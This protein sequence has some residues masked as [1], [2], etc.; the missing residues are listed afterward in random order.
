M[1]WSKMV[2][3]GTE[4]E[5]DLTPRCGRCEEVLTHSSCM[6]CYKRLP[7]SKGAIIYCA[8]PLGETWHYCKPCHIYRENLKCPKCDKKH[9]NRYAKDVE[10]EQDRKTYSDDQDRKS[11]ISRVVIMVMTCRD[12]KHTWE[13]KRGGQNEF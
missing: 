2:K 10:S 12:C 6:E 3:E 13:E 4:A 8:G 1:P 7:V 11:Y 9:V 5:V